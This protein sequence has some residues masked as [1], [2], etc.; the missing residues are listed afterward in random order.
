[1]LCKRATIAVNYTT[2]TNPQNPLAD[3]V[4]NFGVLT[5]QQAADYLQVTQRT[6]ER[7]VRRGRLRAYRPS[8]KV[9]RFR[10]RDLDVF[11]ESSASIAA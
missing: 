10:L 9:C 5:K 11:L 1:M 7:M 3:P 6:I 4:L 8:R 2:M